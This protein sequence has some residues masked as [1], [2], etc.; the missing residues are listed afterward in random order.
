M[1]KFKFSSVVLLKVFVCLISKSF[2]G[3]HAHLP[4]LDALAHQI[5]DRSLLDGLAV[6]SDLVVGKL[7]Q[8][9]LPGVNHRLSFTDT[10]ALFVFNHAVITLGELYQKIDNWLAESYS[11]PRWCRG[12]QR[13]AEALTVFSDDFALAVKELPALKVELAASDV[14][15]EVALHCLVAA[16]AFTGK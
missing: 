5:L 8:A 7:A 9:L 15:R 11:T 2:Q 6:V 16:H 4:A 1:F 14:A 13:H 3:V 10:H 12:M